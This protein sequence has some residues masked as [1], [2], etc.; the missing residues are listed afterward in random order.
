[1][2][3]LFNYESKALAFKNLD[4]EPHF[5]YTS[6]VDMEENVVSKAEITITVTF[7]LKKP[8]LMLSELNSLI[9]KVKTDLT[10]QVLTSEVDHKSK[11][12]SVKPQTFQSLASNCL[13]PVA[14]K[15][16]FHT[17]DRK[18]E[19]SFQIRLVLSDGDLTI[20]D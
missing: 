4:G 14:E 8:F 7:K 1:M 20:I 19:V 18:T 17:Q 3:K 12:L 9:Q 2:G 6:D 13:I 10:G 11:H 15:T 5:V 16:I